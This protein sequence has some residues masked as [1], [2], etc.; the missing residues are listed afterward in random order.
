MH[1]PADISWPHTLKQKDNT[2]C[3][4]AWS[5]SPASHRSE[6]HRKLTRAVGYDKKSRVQMITIIYHKLKFHLHNI[7]P[8]NI[9]RWDIY[10]RHTVERPCLKTL[11][12]Q[13]GRSFGK[14]FPLVW[15]VPDQL[16]VCLPDNH[17]PGF[18]KDNS[19]WA[20]SPLHFQLCVRVR[21][22]AAQCWAEPLQME[23]K[24]RSRNRWE[25]AGWANWAPTLNHEVRDWFHPVSKLSGLPAHF[26]RNL[27]SF[28]PRVDYSNCG[29]SRPRC[30]VCHWWFLS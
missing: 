20:S 19:W 5:Y 4:T 30:F 26:P 27:A 6:Y 14:E 12:V 17:N 24:Q 7:T 23:L 10:T 11:T 16:L 22:E 15:H 8:L 25:V 2:H 29:G 18:H 1:R 9:S 13:N 28:S 21:R 3:H